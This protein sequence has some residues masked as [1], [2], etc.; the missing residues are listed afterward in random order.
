MLIVEHIKSP[1]HWYRIAY[2]DHGALLDWGGKVGS[3]TYSAH[4]TNAEFR[5]EEE[6]REH[7]TATLT[8]RH[9]SACG[10]SC[11]VLT[12]GG[13][14]RKDK[15]EECDGSFGKFSSAAAEVLYEWSLDGQPES[16]GDAQYGNGWHA[17]FPEDR[18]ILHAANSGA[19]SAWPVPDNEWDAHRAEIEAGAVTEDDAS[20][21]ECTDEQACP[22]HCDCGEC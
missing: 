16:C 13:T 5:P 21:C 4:L 6:W 12:W 1:G 19:V 3:A 17:F 15:Y 11:P 14:C 10:L 7:I 18:A 22:E 8:A 9:W 2:N 20:M